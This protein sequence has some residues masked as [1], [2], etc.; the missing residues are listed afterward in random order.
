METPFVEANGLTY[1]LML[2]ATRSIFILPPLTVFS[3]YRVPVSTSGVQ[4]IARLIQPLSV[5]L[6]HFLSEGHFFL[7][8]FVRHPVVLYACK[9]FAARLML[10]CVFVLLMLYNAI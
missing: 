8:M 1:E 9:R 6:V 5:G 10:A 2:R 3:F 7:R 4:R